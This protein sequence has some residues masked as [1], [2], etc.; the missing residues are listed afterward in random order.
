MREESNNKISSFSTWVNENWFTKATNYLSNAADRAFDGTILAGKEKSEP[1]RPALFHTAENL[2]DVIIT[3][4]TKIDNIVSGT[5][6]KLRDR[7]SSSA[8]EIKKFVRDS[9]KRLRVILDSGISG[10]IA[11][12]E[13]DKTLTDINKRY[14]NIIRGGGELEKW[15]GEFIGRQGDLAT[16]SAYYTRGMELINQARA[17][18][19]S[20]NDIDAAKK[21]IESKEI[22]NEFKTLMD[23]IRG[24]EQ[25]EDTNQKNKFE[26]ENTESVKAFRSKLK[27]LGISSNSSSDSYSSD[28]E[29]AAGVA[30]KT[31]SA[32]T[33][34]SYGTSP[35]DLKDLYRDANQVLIH[36]EKL[37]KTILAK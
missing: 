15:S 13:I 37:K 28:D 17:I 1:D 10:E 32:L 20:L 16:N 18:E 12:S 22:Q 27:E 4:G 33:G 14:E 29:E 34:K 3:L 8:S 30:G 36:R 9:Y 35:E 11:S 23:K 25:G 2:L 5:D 7:A 6:G 19:K 21:N 24:K 31:L 26:I